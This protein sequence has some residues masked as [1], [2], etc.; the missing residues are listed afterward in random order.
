MS[1]SNTSPLS[2][3]E[4]R[5]AGKRNVTTE[6]WAEFERRLDTTTDQQIALFLK[7]ASAHLDFTSRSVQQDQMRDLIADE[8]AMRIY[9]GNS[10]AG[11]EPHPG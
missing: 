6:F 2:R 9:D 11:S 3:D 7:E 10:D 5:E 8:V 4:L 1:E